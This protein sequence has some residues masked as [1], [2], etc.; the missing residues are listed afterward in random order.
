MN[1]LQKMLEIDEKKRISS[2]ILALVCQIDQVLFSNLIV[3]H[4]Q[5]FP[6]EYKIIDEASSLCQIKYTIKLLRYEGQYK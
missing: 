1:V 3:P 5:I 4:V 2:P 6:P